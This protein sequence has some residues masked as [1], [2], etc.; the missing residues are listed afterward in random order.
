MRWGSML[1]GISD[2]VFM[3]GYKRFFNRAVRL[4]LYEEGFCSENQVTLPRIRGLI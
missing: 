3:V 2:T 4:V 1:G